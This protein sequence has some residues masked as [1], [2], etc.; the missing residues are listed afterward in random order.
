MSEN[1]IPKINGILETALYVDDV[2]AAAR[3]Y[4]DIFGF[5]KLFNDGRL[6]A[7]DIAPHS[8]LLLF[9]KGASD[10]PNP[11]PGGVIPAH[12]GSGK[13]HFAFSISAEELGAWRT[14]L[15]RND[16]PIE[17]EITPPQGGYSLY[18]RDLDRNLVELATP[19]LWENDK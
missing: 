16:V 6:I 9:K 5:A 15:E 3:W 7:L 14:H 8:V 18:F 10:G 13:L 4:Q 19:G 17:A 2:E 11:S 1:S 12:D